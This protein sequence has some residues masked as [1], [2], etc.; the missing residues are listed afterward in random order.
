VQEG[1]FDHP[2]HRHSMP[3]AVLERF[4]VAMEL[5]LESLEAKAQR[6]AYGVLS[7]LHCGELGWT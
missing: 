4:T 7:C 5:D 6:E 3:L 1:I 2:Y